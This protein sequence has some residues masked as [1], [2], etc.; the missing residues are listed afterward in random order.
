M[1][2]KSVTD[3]ITNSSTEV[4]ILNTDKSLEEVTKILYEISS[5]FKDPEICQKSGEV[6]QSLL[7]FGYIFDKNDPESMEDFYWQVISHSS[8]FDWDTCKDIEIPGIKEI[9]EEF[10]DYIWERRKEINKLRKSSR[11]EFIK[12]DLIKSKKDIDISRYSFGRFPSRFITGF[13]KQYEGTLPSAFNLPEV[14]DVK[15]YVGKVGFIGKGDN[16]IPYES[17]DKINKLFKGTNWY[18]G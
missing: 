9:Q 17:W 18:L 14:M 8:Y 2:I 4:F 3:V 15:T 1:K 5:G 12:K 10:V 7:N 11:Y 6:L 16:S 13:L